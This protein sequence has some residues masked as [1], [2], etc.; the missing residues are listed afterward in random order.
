V[1]DCKDFQEQIEHLNAKLKNKNEEIEVK[2]AEYLKYKRDH[3]SVIRDLQERLNDSEKMPESLS[4]STNAEVQ[5]LQN[6]ID[7]STSSDEEQEQNQVE[8]PIDASTS[9]QQSNKTN[10]ETRFRKTSDGKSQCLICLK[11]TYQIHRHLQSHKHKCEKCGTKFE[12]D[13]AS[14]NLKRHIAIC[15]GPKQLKCKW[16]LKTFEYQSFMLIHQKKCKASLK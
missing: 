1:D 16:C 9:R 6:E 5:R 14:R 2:E 7:P 13:R 15:N 11:K 4:G 10:K 8:I 3:E 12:G